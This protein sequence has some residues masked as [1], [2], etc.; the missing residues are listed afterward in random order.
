M[1]NLRNLV[2]TG[3]TGK[4]GGALVQALL[5]QPSQPFT[6]Y[7]VTRNTASTSAQRLSKQTNVKLIQGDFDEPAAIFRQVDSPWGLFAMTNLMAGEVV[8]EKQGKALIAAAAD[9]GVRHIVFTATERGGQTKS[10][11]E[12]TYVPHFRSKYHVE[13]D[14][15][16][17]AEQSGGQLTWTFLRPVAFFENLAP[18][19]FGKAFVSMWR[20]NG[21]DRPLQ[22]IATVDI[23]KIAADAFLNADSEEYRNKAISIAG[24]ELSPND[25]ARIFKEVTGEEIPSTYGFVGGLLKLASKDMRLMLKWFAE[26]DFGVDVEAVRRRYPFMK[27]FRGWLE[28]S[29]WRKR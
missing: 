4:Q 6:I 16:R 12:P 3:A 26:E 17:H 27:D 11:R 21:G 15:V 10:D 2:V 22:Q 8:E 5:S 7:A 19:F 13:R 14:I 24:D 1:S 23:G 25:A 28:E 9:A 20:G 18:G 29:A